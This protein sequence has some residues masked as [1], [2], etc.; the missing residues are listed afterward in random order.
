MA[1]QNPINSQVLGVYLV[2]QLMHP[3]KGPM[4][5]SHLDHL[6]QLDKRLAVRQI[7][8]KAEKEDPMSNN[9]FR[10]SS[11]NIDYIEH[12]IVLLGIQPTIYS[13]QIIKGNV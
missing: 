11:N 5:E 6:G 8:D 9:F 10:T 3:A 12:I 4:Q 7:K 1:T 13:L 2:Q